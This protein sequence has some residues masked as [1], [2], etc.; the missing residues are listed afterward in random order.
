MPEDIDL[1]PTWP[2][3]KA[4]KWVLHITNRLF[5]RYS[6]P[7]IC[8]EGDEHKFATLLS[9]ECLPQFLEA[10]LKLMATILHGQWLPPRVINLSLHLLSYCVA[11]SE[12]YKLLKPHMNQLLISVVFPIMC[13]DENDAQLWG[14]DPQEYIR[15][16]YDVIEEMYN[17]RTAA[18]NFL[19][20]VCKVRPAFALNRPKH[21]EGGSVLK[22]HQC[23]SLNLLG[24]A[25]SP[26][27]CTR[28]LSV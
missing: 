22:D 4:K 9:Q 3:W 27:P 20:E 17:P 8:K 12:T 21:T 5:S 26:G 25:L 28:A 11:R 19:H 16:G 13:F 23:T 15:K 10:I 24:S 7:N 14:E 18:M 1:R 6:D 2:W